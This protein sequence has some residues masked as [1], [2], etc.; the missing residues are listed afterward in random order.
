MKWKKLS[1]KGAGKLMKMAGSSECFLDT[2][3]IIEVFRNNNSVD[4]S[5]KKIQG[6]FIS[7]IVVG[8]L[9]YGAYASADPQRKLQQLSAFLANCT[10]I[11]CDDTTAMFYGQLKFKLRKQGTPIPENDIWIAALAQQHD[12]PLYTFDNHF[13]HLTPELRLI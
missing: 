7:S 8:E 10:I 12:L 11:S 5:L 4:E 6:L 1:M 9:H 2:N 3:V 13:N